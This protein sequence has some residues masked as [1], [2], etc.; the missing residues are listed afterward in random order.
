MTTITGN[1]AN[2]VLN[3]GNGNDTLRGGDGDDTLIGGN[4]NDVIE[5]QGG[6]DNEQGGGGNDRFVFNVGFGYPNTIDG[7]ANVDTFDFTAIGGGFSGAAIVIDLVAG[8]SDIGG[9]MTLIGLENVLGSD[10]SETIRGNALA[11]SLQGNGGD[12]QIFALQGNDSLSGG[13]GSDTLNGGLNVDAMNG[14]AGSDTYFVDNAGDTTVET[15]G[16][17]AGGTDLVNASVNRTLGANLENLVMFGV[18]TTGT[19]NGLANSITGNAIG[20]TLSGLAGNDI[21]IGGAGP[22]I[23]IGGLNND[24]FVYNALSDSPFGAADRI[25]A[26]GGAI[27]FQ[28]VGGAAGDRIDLTLINSNTNVG[29]NQDFVLDVNLLRSNVGNNTVF[30][31][32]VNGV[33][34]FEFELVVEDGA[35]V[36]AANYTIADFFGVI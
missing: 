3:G 8:Y 32:N 12:D 6:T 4:G 9:T 26:G 19:G 13:S 11:N 2:N 16:G 29:G 1:Q 34:G 31:G 5:G 28:G 18:A 33:A 14:G 35:G 27:A 7:G 21:L 10:S 17:A 25:R 24:T 22:D 36:V 30:R 15:V 23:L 20:N